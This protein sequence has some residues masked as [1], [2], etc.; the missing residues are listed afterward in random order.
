MMGS[1]NGWTQVNQMDEPEAHSTYKAALMA[2]SSMDGDN[3]DTRVLRS[4]FGNL[5]HDGH[6]MGSWI[7]AL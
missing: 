7:T 2:R 6:T 5:V 3:D 4:L 1:D